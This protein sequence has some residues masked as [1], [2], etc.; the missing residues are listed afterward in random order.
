MNEKDT[1]KSKGAVSALIE[2]K[3]GE[4]KELDFPNTVLLS[5]R[6]ALAR[7]LANDFG[8]SYEFFIAR[9]IFGDGGTQS[10]VKKFVEAGREGLFGVTR[11]SKPIVA[12]IDIN[13]PAQVIFTSVIRFD[14]AI[15]VTLNEMALQM[16]TGEFFSMVT[17]PDLNKTEEMQITWNWRLNFI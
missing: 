16:A 11:V 2:W 6:R 8:D 12:N 15:G 3:N 7:S 1:L 4:K 9:M 14:E 13:V 10:G 5:G 17:F